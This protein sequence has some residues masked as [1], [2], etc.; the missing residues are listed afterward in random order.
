MQSKEDFIEMR[1]PASAEYVSLIRLTLSGVFS[2]AG[3]TYD[4]IEDARLQLVK[5]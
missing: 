1:V 4:D 5:L 3:A 2:R